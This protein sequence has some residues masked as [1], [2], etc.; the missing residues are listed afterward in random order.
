MPLRPFKT[1][2]KDCLVRPKIRTASVTVRIFIY[3][4]AES[5]DFLKKIK[6][7]P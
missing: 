7:E 3:F 5:A 4:A 1:L 2:S 6:S